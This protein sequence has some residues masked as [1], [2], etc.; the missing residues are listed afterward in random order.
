MPFGVW[1]GL[2]N[3]V[4]DGGQDPHKWKGN[5][6]GGSGQPRACPEMSGS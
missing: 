5:Y 2:Q 4:L 6:E 1:E 3:H